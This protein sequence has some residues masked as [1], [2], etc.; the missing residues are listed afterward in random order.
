MNA[1]LARIS[2]LPRFAVQDVDL[3]E[4][5]LR[6][7][8]TGKL[9]PVQ[10][11]ALLHAWASG[12][13]LGAIGVGA[14][15]TLICLL[16][17][18]LFGA[19]RAL[20]LIPASLREQLENM[21]QD[22]FHDWK[23]KNYNQ[24]SYSQLSRP[25]GENKL[26]NYNPDL[27]IADEAH[28]LRDLQSARTQ[29]IQRYLKDYP[30]TR[31]VA[32]SGTI[33]KRSIHDYAHLCEWALRGR[34]PLPRDRFVLGSLARIVDP[35]ETPLP[36]DWGLIGQLYRGRSQSEVRAEYQ[37]R[38]VSTL[39]VL[40]YQSI[41]DCDASIL[42]TLHESL[43]LPL[44]VNNAL[45]LATDE[46]KTING[47]Y[48]ASD[49][50]RWRYKYQMSLGYFYF[51]NVDGP[52]VEDWIEAKNK[53]NRTVRKEIKRA[54]RFLYDSP[55]LIAEAIENENELVPHAVIAA[56]EEWQ[57]VEGLTTGPKKERMV[58]DR[59]I[60][61]SIVE[62]F[63]EEV[64]VFWYHHEAVA[65]LLEEDGIDVYR[66]GDT[67]P[68]KGDHTI[69]LSITSHSDGL[70]LQNYSKCVVL[71][72]PANGQAW[73]QIIGRFHRTGQTADTVRVHVM[74]HTEVFR[75]AMRMAIK[76]TKYIEETKGVKFRLSLADF[77]KQ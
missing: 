69:A 49:V 8:G 40:V 56:W 73:E 74:Q 25:D 29:R 66:A 45:V 59:G 43:S 10:S 33:T 38:L 7:D 18:Y 16:M 19:K 47:D 41:K 70:N 26:R 34:N 27:I 65:D 6:H 9:R 11:S 35:G 22:Y 13:L 67:P 32:L 48:F 46:D 30:K 51:Q 54:G 24:L 31:F 21:R 17:P 15:K 37:A 53:W 36:T 42:V 39:G 62:M 57:K 23:I 5:F 2:T 76:D 72:P 63:R 1:E 3:T 75:K 44:V 64:V 71:E 14:G 12:G 20:V 61:G 52:L 4:R 50:E 55:T 58:V 28:Y 60:L 68:N 77:H